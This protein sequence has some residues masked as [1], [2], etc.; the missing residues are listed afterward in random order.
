[1]KPNEIA[2]FILDTY[3]DINKMDDD[4]V[5]HAIEGGIHRLMLENMDDWNMY[6]VYCMWAKKD[7]KDQDATREYIRITDTIQ[8]GID[9][10]SR[11]YTEVSHY[12][13]SNSSS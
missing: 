11:L 3:E 1:M 8:E 10:K 6:K 5:P 9:E 7:L 4:L 12:K 13:T 2:D